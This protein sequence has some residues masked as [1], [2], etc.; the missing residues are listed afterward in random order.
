VV[1]HTPPLAAATNQVLGRLG[2]TAT[3]ITRP[4]VSAGPRPR[5]S[6][7]AKPSAE[8]GSFFFSAA[9]FGAEGSL[10]VAG[11]AGAGQGTVSSRERTRAGRVLMEP[12]GT[13]ILPLLREGA[14][15]AKSGWPVSRVPFMMGALVAVPALTEA[16]APASLPDRRRRCTRRRRSRLVAVPSWARRRTGHLRGGSGDR[17]GWRLDPQAAAP[18]ASRSGG[19]VVASLRKYTADLDRL[20]HE[21]ARLTIMALL[22]AVEEAAPCPRSLRRWPGRWPRCRRPPVASPSPAGS[23]RPRR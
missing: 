1:F 22:H 21:P 4:E 23:G 11:E 20:I 6:R 5:S 14:D 15:P 12:P 7:P 3:S 2:S 8:S 16:P 18:A 10:V 9:A 19:V 17:R 13:G